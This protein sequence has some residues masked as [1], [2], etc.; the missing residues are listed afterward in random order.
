M[1]YRFIGVLLA[2]LCSGTVWSAPCVPDLPERAIP[3]AGESSIAMFARETVK[4]EYRPPEKMSRRG[5]DYLL[6]MWNAVTIYPCDRSR[7][8]TIEIK[9]F[10]I[11]RLDAV[12]GRLITEFSVRFGGNGGSSFA[13]GGQW[14]R[15]PE[16]FISG[17]PE[18]QPT[19]VS[20]REGIFRVDL[21][22]I[23]EAIVHMWTDRIPAVPGDSYGIRAEVRVV[24]DARL[25]LAMDYWKGRDSQPLP[26]AEDCQGMNHCE[27]WLGD[28]IGDTKG[29]FITVLS[30]RSLLGNSR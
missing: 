12:T 14:K 13:G 4:D 24:G 28:W 15:S 21:K 6:G 5:F 19:V 26:W 27:A 25:Q 8:A 11:V 23:P 9:N 20:T 16:W 30:P 1:F 17:Q 22:S 3:Q 10:E 7:P 2:L 29:E 18:R